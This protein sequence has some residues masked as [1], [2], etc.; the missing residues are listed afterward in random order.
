MAMNYHENEDLNGLRHSWNVLP[1]TRVDASRMVL[2]VG[3]LYTPL[4][5]IENMPVVGYDPVVCKS[6]RGILNPYCR[7]NFQSKTWDCP[8]C[9]SRNVFPQAYMGISETV[10]QFFL[11]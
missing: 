5:H 1:G 11:H 8:L 10:R 9:L 3:A 4:K 6:C 2:P 7:P